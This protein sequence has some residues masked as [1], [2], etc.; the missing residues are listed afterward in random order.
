MAIGQ[1]GI[2]AC[3]EFLLT[4][5]GEDEKKGGVDCVMYLLVVAV[6]LEPLC[7][8]RVIYSLR[9]STGLNMLCVVNDE[10]FQ[11]VTESFVVLRQ[12]GEYSR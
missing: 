9:R 3:V 10:D 8:K 4:L 12:G 1:P 2:F 11:N 6:T 7:N 5:C